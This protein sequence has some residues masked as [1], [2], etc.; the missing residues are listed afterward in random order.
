MPA[1]LI[2]AV[3][4]AKKFDDLGSPALE[5]LAFADFVGSGELDRHL[6]RMRPIYRARRDALLGALR[7]HLPGLRP[8]GASAGLHVLAWLPNG[9]DE[10]ALLRA[11]T[12]A[13]IGLET[14]AESRISEAGP[15]GII[16]GYGSVAEP[17]ID[18][19]VR[20]LAGLSAWSPLRRRPRAR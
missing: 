10:S 7:R 16:V 13:G 11:A 20:R 18:E 5:Q 19:S 12:D 2:D 1:P 15:G 8:V 17:A 6:R 14:L 3:A 4:E 9:V